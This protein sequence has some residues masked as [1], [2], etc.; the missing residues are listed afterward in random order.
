MGRGENV[1]KQKPSEFTVSEPLSTALR[2]GRV[3]HGTL[4]MHVSRSGGF[5]VEYDGRRASDHR[6]DY[7]NEGRIR[8]MAK[9][10]LREMAEK[11]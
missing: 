4:W 7:H 3:A 6:T 9:M 2:D 10:I 1:K 5:E 11:A 8:F